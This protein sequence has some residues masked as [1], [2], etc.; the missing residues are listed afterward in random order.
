M[1]II[2]LYIMLSGSWR[3]YKHPFSKCDLTLITIRSFIEISAALTLIICDQ[4]MRR[5]LRLRT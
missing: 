1:H 2:E 4:D 3:T 5:K